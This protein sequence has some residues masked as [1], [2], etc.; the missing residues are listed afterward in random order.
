VFPLWG[1]ETSALAREFIAAHFQ[2]V[3]VCVDPRKLDASFAGRRFDSELL[4]DLPAGV[5]PCGENGESHTFVY[6]GPIFSE[7]IPCELGANRLPGRL[8]VP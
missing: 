7:P 4:A 1:R 3:L 5:D 8:G 6:G 2:A